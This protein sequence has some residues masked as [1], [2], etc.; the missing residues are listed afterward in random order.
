MQN[1]EPC[2]SCGGFM[3]R[4]GL[5]PHCGEVAQPR[6]QS[7]MG[8][9]APRLLQAAI[10]GS[11]AMTLMACYGAPHAYMQPGEA[12]DP[13]ADQDGDGFPVREDCDDLSP[14][15][16]PGAADTEGDGID[17]DCD[18]SDAPKPKEFAEPPPDDKPPLE[19]ATPPAE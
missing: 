10:G 11:L 13:N 5:C 4:A 14:D 6:P 7:R 8:R 15:I 3:P 19:V 9:F 17:S 16:H 2:V 12:M 18:G 1:L